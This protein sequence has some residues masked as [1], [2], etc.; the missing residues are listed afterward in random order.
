MTE[1]IKPEDLSI[2]IISVGI[3]GEGIIRY[4]Y[5]HIKS[6]FKSERFGDLKDKGKIHD[7]IMKELE[8]KVYPS[9]DRE[10]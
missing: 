3:L 6:G 7:E 5:T 10:R 4:R 1:A 8:G 2:D 9:S